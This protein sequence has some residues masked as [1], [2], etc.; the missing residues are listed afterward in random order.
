MFESKLVHIS[1]AL[2]LKKMGLDF[3]ILVTHNE[4]KD[5]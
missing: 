5:V 1:G 4:S 2:E 3:S